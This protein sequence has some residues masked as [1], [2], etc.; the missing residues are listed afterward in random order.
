MK[1]EAFGTEKR[2]KDVDKDEDK[3]LASENLRLKKGIKFIS[4]FFFKEESHDLFKVKI[5][6]MKGA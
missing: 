3:N 1:K 4:E 5:Y 6:S 2:D